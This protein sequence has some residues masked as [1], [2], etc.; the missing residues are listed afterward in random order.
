MQ[1]VLVNECLN[2]MDKV[3]FIFLC[4]CFRPSVVLTIFFFFYESEKQNTFL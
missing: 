3:F 4:G 2:D 1:I